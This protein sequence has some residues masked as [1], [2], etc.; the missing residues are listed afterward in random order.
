MS[1]RKRRSA[2]HTSM[3]FRGAPWPSGIVD[4]EA[5]QDVA[6]FYRGILAQIPTVAADP[7]DP[8][9]TAGL[10]GLW[11]LD[12]GSGEGSAKDSSGNSRDLTT[13]QNVT[14]YSPGISGG[15]C[16]SFG[17]R[18]VIRSAYG[19]AIDASTWTA[20]SVSLWCNRDIA[21]VG[22]CRLFCF[23]ANNIDGVAIYT[24]A[25]VY[26]GLKTMWSRAG[27]TEYPS[28]ILSAFDSVLRH[29]VL[30]FNLTS[31]AWIVYRD[32][33]TKGSGTL[34]NSPVMPNRAFVLGN[35]NSPA[36]LT[37]WSGLIDEV[38]LYS[39]VLTPAEVTALY[40]NPTQAPRTVTEIWTQKLAND[41]EAAMRAMGY[42]LVD[43]E[44]P[45]TDNHYTLA[46]EQMLGVEHRGT[47]AGGFLRVD[48]RARVRVQ[49]GAKP[50]NKRLVRTIGEAQEE[51]VMGLYRMTGRVG[52]FESADLEDVEGGH[53][54]VILFTYRG[55]YT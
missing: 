24:D 54:S 3:P 29:Y 11:H 28:T 32:G 12:E 20:F 40:V 7:M 5:R 2:I 19:A 48:A 36:A 33:T 46:V 45:I 34:T 42:V 14:R 39:R 21:A 38:R 16:L 35:Y 23:G 31:K 41:I 30:T 17:N 18:T 15:R 26:D 8:I 13:L 51:I 53:V 10:E 52:I 25:V 6:G 50:K 44:N 49:H 37:N 27:A 43:D 1:N 22:S 9:S 4:Q 55:Y 47:L